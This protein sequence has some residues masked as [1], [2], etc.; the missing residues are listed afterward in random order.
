MKIEIRRATQDDLPEAKR[1]VSAA[2]LPVEDLTA[3]NLA[4]VAALGNDVVGVIGLEDFGHVG[5]LRS[6]VVAADSRTAGLGHDLV[7]ALEKSAREREMGELWLLTTDADPFFSQLGYQIR[8][9]NSAPEA[10]RGTAE[11]IELCPGDAFLMCKPL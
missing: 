10:I 4:F 1:L 3:D 7:A 11:F 2:G 6:L 5:L 8:G 9:R